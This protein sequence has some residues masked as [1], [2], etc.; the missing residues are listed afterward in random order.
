MPIRLQRLRSEMHRSF[1]RILGADRISAFC[2]RMAGF[3]KA[4]RGQVFGASARRFRP[5]LIYLFFG[6]QSSCSD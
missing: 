2:F 1:V 3:R 4:F 6:F 5:R